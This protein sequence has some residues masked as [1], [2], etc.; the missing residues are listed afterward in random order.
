MSNKVADNL[1][2]P[3]GTDLV[4]QSVA[5]GGNLNSVQYEVWVVNS[6]GN[7]TG[8]GVT[9]VLQGSNDGLNWSAL[10]SGTT[11]T[12]SPS[13]KAFDYAAVISYRQVRLKFTA[14]GANA[15]VDATIT[16]YKRS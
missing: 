6:A 16:P 7:L 15:L 5:L 11:A 13:Y 10:S 4:T 14:S 3:S 2:C 12:V 1:F 8:N 9:P